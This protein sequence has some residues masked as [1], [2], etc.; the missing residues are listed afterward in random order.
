LKSNSIIQE[1]LADLRAR[2]PAGMTPS[3]AA[4]QMKKRVRRIAAIAIGT[5]SSEGLQEL[6][7]A[8]ALVAIIA[9]MAMETIERACDRG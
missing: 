4:V 9:Q 3:D 1:G 6:M 8:L 5:P 2:L 7:V